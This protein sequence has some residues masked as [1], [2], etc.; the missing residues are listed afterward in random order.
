VKIPAISD[1]RFHYATESLEAVRDADLARGWLLE[2]WLVRARW[3]IAPPSAL[4]LLLFPSIHIASSA[5]LALWIAATNALV[6]RL[7]AGP[8]SAARL[9]VVRR[10]ACVSDWTACIATV[11]LFLPRLQRMCALWC[12]YWSS[13]RRSVMAPAGSGLP[14]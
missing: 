7:L 3:L 1:L 8:P 10:V 9:R 14:S 4:L 12:C 5:G 11:A 13:L 2:S 6:Q